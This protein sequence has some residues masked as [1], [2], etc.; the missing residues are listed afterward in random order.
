MT[1]LAIP[2]LLLMIGSVSCVQIEAPNGHNTG[3]GGISSYEGHSSR[4][5]GASGTS[6]SSTNVGQGPVAESGAKET[7][8]NAQT[9]S[10]SNGGVALPT[11]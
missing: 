3:G 11:Q 2:A 5:A 6:S 4:I 9:P 7:L 10:E 8:T 1:K